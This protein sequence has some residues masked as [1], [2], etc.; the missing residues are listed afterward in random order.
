M[1]MM[2]NLIEIN[3]AF[4]SYKFYEKEHYYTYNGQKVKYSVTQYIATKH[5]DFDLEAISAY[6][7]NRDN[8]PQQ[9]VIDEWNVN[10]L[11]S[12]TVG[13]LFHLRSEQLAQN[14]II[15][16]DYSSYEDKDYFN[17]IKTRLDKLIVLQDKFFADIYSKLIPIKEEF[18]VGYKDI[19]AGNI[20]LLCWNEKDQEYQI[21][22]YK[23]NKQINTINKYEKL[24]D[25]F[26]EL[27]DCEFNKYSIQL[28]IYKQ[29]LEMSLNIKIGKCYLA[30][31]NENN[32]DYKIFKCLDLSEEVKLALNNLIGESNGRDNTNK[33]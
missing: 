23:T 3:K 21:W 1:V 27:D 26:N 15:D 5:K 6:V 24:F 2:D 20:D 25:E 22:D 10:N 9:V 32:D 7:A 31:F 4:N 16:I 29:L 12:C 11:I 18:T 28:N 33:S 13:T 14:K 19:I 8:K 17:Q 30:W